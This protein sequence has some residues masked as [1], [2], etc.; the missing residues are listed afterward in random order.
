MRTAMLCQKSLVE[1]IITAFPMLL[2]VHEKA[3]S[4]VRRSNMSRRD[5]NTKKT[6][7][8]D[9]KHT[10]HRYGAE[11]PVILAASLLTILDR[12]NICKKCR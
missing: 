7:R 12:P 10:G 8:D 5:N 4:R 9:Q 11:A 2:L 6:G 3:S 1:V